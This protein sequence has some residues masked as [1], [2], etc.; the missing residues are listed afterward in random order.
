MLLGSQEQEVFKGII[1][2]SGDDA[3]KAAVAMA[4]ILWSDKMHKAAL[5]ELVVSRL[6]IMANQI[7]AG[8]PN[9][10]MREAAGAYGRGKV[11]P[12]PKIKKLPEE[13]AGVHRE[14]RAKSKI[15]ESIWEYRLGGDIVGKIPW[16]D[17]PGIIESNLSRGD[18]HY[19]NAEI[20]RQLLKL[21]P[22][23]RKG[24]IGDSVS[25]RAFRKIFEKVSREFRTAANSR[26]AARRRKAS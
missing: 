25:E 11:I 3:R 10:K 12:L 21:A 7:I 1:D 6:E 23:N 13:L 4:K 22:A 15:Q 16:S 20:A 18:G 9:R 2:K 14:A 8:R 5:E 19:R 26:T 24:R 17:L